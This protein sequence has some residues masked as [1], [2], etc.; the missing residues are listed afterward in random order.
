MKTS[1]ERYKKD[2]ILGIVCVVIG[3]CLSILLLGLFPSEFVW[4][5]VV[6]VIPLFVGVMGFYYFLLKSLS[7]IGEE[8]GIR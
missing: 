5:R 4:V 7:N 8:R 6:H 1:R 3:T 2:M